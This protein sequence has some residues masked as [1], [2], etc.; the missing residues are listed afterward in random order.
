[1]RSGAC[2]RPNYRRQSRDH[3]RAIIVV[4]WMLGDPQTLR[5]RRPIASIIALMLIPPDNATMQ[6]DELVP[7]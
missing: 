3:L 2:F 7:Y 1:M 6:S 4:A 5:E